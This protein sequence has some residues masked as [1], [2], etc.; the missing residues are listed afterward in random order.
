MV[1]TCPIFNAYT[2]PLPTAQLFSNYLEDDKP[3][4]IGTDAYLL[5]YT[6]WIRDW[7]TH[8]SVIS[9]TVLVPPE[10]TAIA[11]PLDLTVAKQFMRTSQYCLSPLLYLWDIPRLQTWLQQPLIL[12][13]ISPQKYDF[14]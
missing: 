13:Q 2:T 1:T 9:D 3:P 12:A 8:L 11:T 10:A 6:T 4:F 5:S 14:D 7:T